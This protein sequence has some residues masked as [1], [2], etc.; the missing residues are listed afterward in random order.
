MNDS[1]I[2]TL[3]VAFTIWVI[4]SVVVSSTAVSL[5]DMQNENKANDKRMKIFKP[6]VFLILIKI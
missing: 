1:I 4:C 5:S 3:G 6:L 2:K